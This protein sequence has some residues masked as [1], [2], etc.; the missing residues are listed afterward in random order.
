MCSNVG[1]GGRERLGGVCMC[2][3]AQCE[4]VCTVK[5]FLNLI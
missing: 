1:G 2:E 4:C 5:V 3:H